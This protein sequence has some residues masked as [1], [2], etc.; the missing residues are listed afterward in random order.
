MPL[1]AA[2]GE[3]LLLIN[4]SNDGSPSR[5][6]NCAALATCSKR[7]SRGPVQRSAVAHGLHDQPPF[8][9]TD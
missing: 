7:V 2:N 9:L 6:S 8:G 5:R 4:I 3:T 1:G